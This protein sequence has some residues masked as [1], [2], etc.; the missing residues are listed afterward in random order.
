[1]KMIVS[2]RW[3]VA[4]KRQ[5]IPDPTMLPW[6]RVL[7]RRFPGRWREMKHRLGWTDR[8]EW[9]RVLRLAKPF[10]DPKVVAAIRSTLG[11]DARGLSQAVREEAALMAQR[12]RENIGKYGR[13]RIV[14][15]RRYQPTIERM[16]ADAAAKPREWR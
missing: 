5:P 6:V 10:E 13:A 9:Y 14:G 8:I 4:V 3:M 16:K 2:G 11:F 12:R 7:V 1:L 15:T